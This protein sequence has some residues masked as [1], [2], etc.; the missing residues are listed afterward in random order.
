MPDVD[1]VCVVGGGGVTWVV[2]E[3]GGGAAWVV[4]VGGGGAAWVVVV[5][6]AA[7]VVIVAVE[8]VVG[9]GGGGVVCVVVT[10]A[11][12]AAAFGCARALCLRFFA[13]GLAAV[14]ALVV[15]VAV[16]AVVAAAAG[17]LALCVEVEDADPHALT[18]K[19]S[20]TAAVAMRTSFM[21]VSLNPPIFLASL[22]RTPGG[23]GCFPGVRRGSEQPVNAPPPPSNRSAGAATIPSWR[24]MSGARCSWSTMSLRSPRSSPAI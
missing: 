20:S 12:C 6:G 8:V 13:G 14:V 11:V 10:F 15:L 2:V 16:V 19:A 17:A 22:L 18:N 7:W 3:G 21:A 9:G 1:V 23:A 5:G 24:T 4:M